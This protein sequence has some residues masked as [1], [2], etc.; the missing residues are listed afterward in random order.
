MPKMKSKKALTKRVKVSG[1][2]KLV[3]HSAFTSHLAPHK[4]H[5]Q[6]RHARKARLIDKTD[7]K[8]IKY[9]IQN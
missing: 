8:R 7:Y 9:L 4:T 6:K 1:S 3:R 2:G 5:K